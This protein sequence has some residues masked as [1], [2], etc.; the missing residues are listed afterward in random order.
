[1]VYPLSK[2]AEEAPDRM[3]VSDQLRTMTRNEVN[4]RVNRLIK[5]FRSLQLNAGSRLAIVSGN[6]ADYLCTALA[7]GL[8]GIS[9]VPINWHLKS[10]E[11]TYLLK[12]SNADAVAIDPEYRELGESAAAAAGIASQIDLGTIDLWLNKYDDSE[13][14]DPGPFTSVIYYTSGTTGRP[15]G[16]RLAQTPTSMP[17]AQAIE[18]LKASAG[19][20]GQDESTIFL[21]PGPLYHAAPLNTSISAILLGGTLHLMR[22]FEP[23][24]MLHLIDQHKVQR[25]TMVPIMCIRLLRISQETRAKYDVSSLQEVTHLAAHMPTHVK[26]EMIKWWGPILV[27]AYGSS[28]VGVVTRISSQEWLEKPGSVGKPIPSL[29][30]QIIGENN[31]ELPAGE[32]GMIYITSLTDLDISYLD[33]DEK[34]ASVHRAEKQF[35]IGDV[36]YLDDDGHLFL[37]DRRVDMINSGGVNIYPAEIESVALLHPAIEDIGVFGIPN[38][39]WGQETKAAIALREGYE[40]SSRLATDIQQFLSTKLASYKVPRSI[41][42]MAELPRYSNGKLHRRELR[43]PYWADSESVPAS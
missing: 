16:T 34:T 3:M 24:E 6:N 32:T 11:A 35:T 29:T 21:T 30:L 18:R 33:D 20:A 5:H 37:V 23:E 10:P 19:A 36:G 13:P 1:M 2:Y 42:F 14:E 8:A 15:K 4:T 25:I 7:A 12:T 17:L 22:R 9:L 28:E 38:S 43:D 41:D 39:E 26:H 27:D 31:E 40:P